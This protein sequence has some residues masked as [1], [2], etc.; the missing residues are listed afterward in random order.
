M[1]NIETVLKNGYIEATEMKHINNVNKQYIID[2]W[3][4]VKNKYTHKEYYIIPCV[5]NNSRDKMRFDLLKV[6]CEYQPETLEEK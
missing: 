4:Y 5:G 2:K 3:V 1:E 6:T